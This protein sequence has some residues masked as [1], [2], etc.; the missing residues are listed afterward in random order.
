MLIVYGTNGYDIFDIDL[1]NSSKIDSFTVFSIYLNSLNISTFFLYG[2]D[3]FRAW[4]FP[5]STGINGIVSPPPLNHW[6]QKL[7]RWF[8]N[9]A[10]WIKPPRVPEWILHWHTIFGGTIGAFFAQ[11]YF[12]H[13]T[14]SQK[15]QP[16]FRKALIIQ[17]ILLIVIGVASANY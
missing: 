9:F 1:T 12:R 6:S 8:Q 11:R 16:V 7:A 14:S 15:F 13:K 2:Y 3:K 5:K 10:P 4:I 17:I